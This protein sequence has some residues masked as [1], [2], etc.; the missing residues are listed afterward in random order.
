MDLSEHPPTI[1]NAFQR[2]VRSHR[3]EVAARAHDGTQWVDHRWI[4]LADRVD[5]VA[6]ALIER[7][8]QYGDRVAIIAT[9]SLSWF[10]IELAIFRVGAVVVPVYPTSGVGDVEHVLRDS[11]A[12]VAFVG[13]VAQLARLVSVNPRIPALRRVVVMSDEAIPRGPFVVE[14]LARLTT[15]TP[16]ASF[17]ALALLEDPMRA[18][19]AESLAMLM[20]TSGTTGHPKG[21]IV[22][23]R[24]VLGSSVGVMAAGFLERDDTLIFFLPLAHCFAQMQVCVWLLCGSTVV[25]ARSIEKVVDDMGETH[26]TA[27]AGVPRLFEKVYNKVVG[28]GSGAP[29]LKGFL[30]RRT[31]AALE[32]W[33]YARA[34]GK[35]FR[36]FWLFVG[37]KLVLPK[38]REKLLARMGGKLRWMASG[39]APLS[40]PIMALFE[41]AG[42]PIYE[43]YGLTECMACVTVNGGENRP[44]GSVGFALAGSEIR[45][46]EDGEVLIR[47]PGVTAGYWNLPDATRAAIDGNGWLHSGD[48]GV[49]GPDGRLRI[50]DRKK[51]IIIT[52]GGKNV[53]PQNAE[54]AL[55]TCP[56]VSQV[57][58]H[59]DRRPFLTAVV[60]VSEENARAVLRRRGRDESHL[61]YHALSKEPIVRAIL[62]E[63]FDRFN[64]TAGRFESIKRFVVLDHDLTLEGGAL[65]ATLKLR[66]T[67][68]YARYAYVFDGMYDHEH[69][70]TSRFTVLAPST[71]TP[72][73]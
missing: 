10:V 3:D 35:S 54:N 19:S 62:Q 69:A 72:G 59:G 11:R 71:L 65:T 37:R 24:N 39:G 30:F 73:N 32:G 25:F 50:T 9:T 4:D 20:Y 55:K 7:G 23:H 41:A 67:A 5:V 1:L 33:A 47:G 63:A 68:V 64:A 31:I 57:V 22:S 46:A 21:V 27:F 49:I 44:P 8:V 43:G 2:I 56:L 52:A 58:V 13:D 40:P 42:F 36:S 48:I 17:S 70:K 34:A 60:T 26:P 61:D 6:L 28:D 38:V 53:A 66:R 15:D 12:S 51:D 45:L 16:G 29:G 14:S 18:L